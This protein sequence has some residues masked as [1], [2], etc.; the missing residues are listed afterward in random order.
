MNG[1]CIIFSVA[2][3]VFQI[4]VEN[5]DLFKKIKNEYRKENLNTAKIQYVILITEEKNRKEL[6]WRESKNKIV[7]N[8]LNKKLSLKYIHLTIKFLV[9]YLCLK[10]KVLLMH[11]SS[12][13][14]G[15]RGF[16][17][18]GPSGSGKSTIIKEYPH[19][20]LADDVVVLKRGSKNW[21]IYTTPFDNK[22]QDHL[23]QQTKTLDT[24][25]FLHQSEKNHRS[26]IANE[27]AIKNLLKNNW[28]YLYF[29]PRGVNKATNI[30][31]KT[32]NFFRGDKP[33]SSVIYTPLFSLIDRLSKDTKC[34][35]LYS[36]KDHPLKLSLK[37]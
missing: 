23:S 1:H 12:N 37:L 32:Y 35:N 30:Q 20:I 28:L 2:D 26:I 8:Y 29:H 19:A 24:I 21:L 36:T 13:Y 27:I 15:S 33:F 3:I 7:I 25:Y 16:I 11:G 6:L 18:C 14:F 34:Y 10:H 4:Q 9:S 5:F 22:K 31:I 17:Y